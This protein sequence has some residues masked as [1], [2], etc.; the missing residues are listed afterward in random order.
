MKIAILGPKGTYTE[1]AAE[2]Y[3]RNAEIIFYKSITQVFKS[4]NGMKENV[5]IA[6]TFNKIG[7]PVN[8]TLDCLWEYN[9]KMHLRNTDNVRITDTIVLDIVHCI[10][11]MHNASKIEKIISCDQAL[12]QC[13]RYL[14]KHYPNA[15]REGASS[16]AQAAELI[17]MKKMRY[18]AAIGSEAALK[19]YGLEITDRD[20]V[21]KNK[22]IFAVISKICKTEPTGN[23]VT[24]L[25]LHPE[26]DEPEFLNGIKRI[27]N[28]GNIKTTIYP[29]TDGIWG[30]IHYID[31]DGH[32]KDGHVANAIDLIRHYI[33]KNPAELR[34]LGSY[35]KPI[36]R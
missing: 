21:K 34:M 15:E 12:R 2:K 35:K 25:A 5:G 4:I 36:R 13:S 7:G 24:C 11:T 19:E 8:E 16:T 27:L 14:D 6:P 18:A 10:G 20:V 22:T 26:N 30:V 28:G 23:D 3:D 33:M 1:K 17:A 31:V 29:R 9:S 32:E